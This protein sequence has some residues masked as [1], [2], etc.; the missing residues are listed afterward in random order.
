[1]AAKLRRYEQLLKGHGV[2]LEDD[3]E[4]AG[5]DEG[6]AE[7]RDFSTRA[8]LG[9]GIPRADNAEKGTL[10]INKQEAH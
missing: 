1:M 7:E 4:P 8:A 2:K 6:L 9:I 5:V 3:G 10:F